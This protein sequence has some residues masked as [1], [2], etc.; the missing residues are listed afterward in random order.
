MMISV[1][2][3]F[4]LLVLA[5]NVGYAA[6]ASNSNTPLPPGIA[7]QQGDV[8]LVFAQARATNKPVFLYWGAE[9]CPPC[10]QV[11]ATIFNQAAFIERTR[12][13]IPVYLDGDSRNAQKLAAQFKVR[14][15]P[16]M[17][18]F[19][20]DGAEITR[21]PGEV[22]P[23]RYL[24]VLTLGLAAARPV[25]ATLAAALHDGSNLSADEWRLISD[26]DWNSNE[27]QVIEPGKLAETLLTLA[28]SVPA[29]EVD[30]ATRIQL[31]ALVA[32]TAEK[33]STVDQV[34]GLETLHK[35]LGDAR[36]TRANFDLLVN[37]ASEL[38]EL[39]TK[40]PSAV[41]AAL[42]GEWNAPLWRLS[43]DTSLSMADRLTAVTALVAIA[44][45]DGGKDALADTLL[46]AVRE[47]V[48]Q[49]DKATTN[50]Y[51]RHAVIS[52]AADTLA[53]AGLLDESDALL[54]SEIKRSRSPYYLMLQLAANA[55]LRGD[56]KLAL[57]WYERA[58]GLA[59]GSA[60]RLQWG[61][62]Y[63]SEIVDL[64]PLDEARLDRAAQSV[65]KELAHMQD[66][67]YERNRRSVEKLIGKLTDWN[68]DRQ[69]ERSARKVFAQIRG[70][71]AKLP[72][73]DPQRANCESLFD[74]TSAS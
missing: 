33:T 55:K 58:Y 45:L 17:V 36:L 62:N 15:Y 7:W 31:K 30:I 25:K 67:F 6:N 34:A 57:D 53:M 19:K 42:I 32:A 41:R 68:K 65:T 69:H 72:T 27:A 16:T 47:H 35:V 39:M 22:D 29:D 1:R 20:P 18:L 5:T 8:A 70:L 74:A 59:A 10:N 71:C 4:A 21:L 3:F 61:V 73:K 23:L 56:S 26:Y 24:Q 38:T 11:K 52:T 43:D 40:S 48:A 64:A 2:S 51:E 63:I 54:K 60:T 9:W 46:A 14:G 13:F 28:K 37:Y 12:Q 49:A 66:G 50:G 44:K